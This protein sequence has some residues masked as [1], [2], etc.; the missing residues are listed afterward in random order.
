[1]LQFGSS[2]AEPK[3]HLTERRGKA[4]P[5]VWL[6]PQAAWLVR[7]TSTNRQVSNCFARRRA[8]VR[9]PS[10]GEPLRSN[11]PSRSRPRT[12]GMNIH[13]LLEMA[14]DAFPDPIA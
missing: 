6:A 3:W 2:V 12:D 13:L 10:M 8:P 14:A 4:E 5:S 9:S 7:G 1:M 11:R